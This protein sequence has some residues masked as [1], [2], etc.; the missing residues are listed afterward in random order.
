MDVYASIFQLCVVFIAFSVRK[1]EKHLLKV[2]RSRQAVSS[3]LPQH[4]QTVLLVSRDF[5][6][7]PR[8]PLATEDDHSLCR[9]SLSWLGIRVGKPC[10]SNS[11]PLESPGGS[12]YIVGSPLQL[13]SGVLCHP[14]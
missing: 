3:F 2:L 5:H 7:R 11:W 8:L 10:V 12:R 4:V 1:R 14:H 9:V 6:H 13:C